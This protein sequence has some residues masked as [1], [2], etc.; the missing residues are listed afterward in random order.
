MAFS[1]QPTIIVISTMY[2]LP[3]VSLSVAHLHGDELVFICP[4][5]YNADYQAIT[6]TIK[7]LRYTIR[8]EFV[9]SLLRQSAPIVLSTWFDQFVLIAIKQGNGHT[10]RVIFGKAPLPVSASDG[11]LSTT[12]L[13]IAHSF[14]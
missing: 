6:S 14:C 9:F 2:G 8:A 10:V 11:N 5:K 13:S 1:L 4:N 7:G 3:K 12:G